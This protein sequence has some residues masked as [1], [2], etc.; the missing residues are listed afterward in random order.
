MMIDDEL[1]EATAEEST[2][3][4]VKKMYYI[5]LLRFPYYGSHQTFFSSAMHPNIAPTALLL[6]ILPPT[7]LP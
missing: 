7:A 1:A 2:T 4:V 6:P 3:A 5:E